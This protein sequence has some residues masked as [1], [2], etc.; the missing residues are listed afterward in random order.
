MLPLAQLSLRLRRR[1]HNRLKVCRLQARADDEAAV[2]I[3]LGHEL[4]DVGR[5]DIAAV[6]HPQ[7]VGNRER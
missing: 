6:Q 2:D 3:G 4:D 1:S 7:A 5:G